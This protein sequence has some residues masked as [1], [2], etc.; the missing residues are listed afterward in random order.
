MIIYVE[1][2]FKDVILLCHKNVGG[3]LQ[4]ILQSIDENITNLLHLKD[5]LC[6]SRYLIGN[7]FLKDYENVNQEEAFT[8]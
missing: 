8:D 1:Y 4:K 7:P 5:P 2:K 6:F 3:F